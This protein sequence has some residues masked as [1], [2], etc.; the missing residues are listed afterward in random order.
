MTR[1][2]DVLYCDDIRLEAGDKQSYIGVYSGDMIVST[3]PITLPKLGIAVKV[4]TDIDD[5]FDRLQVRV[6]MEGKTLSDSGPFPSEVLHSS[7]QVP[8]N[9]D[10]SRAWRAYG[11]SFILS[12]VVIEKPTKLRVIV[13]TERESLRGRALRIRAL[14]EKG[15]K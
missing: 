3:F 1:H 13:D 5:A 8:K 2:V 12:P 9:D 10:G 11:V 14:D 15:E 6:E 7:A 4:T